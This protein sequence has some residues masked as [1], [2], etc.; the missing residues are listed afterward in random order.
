MRRKLIRWT[1]LFAVVSM[2]VW[3]TTS[4]IGG[5]AFKSGDGLVVG[6]LGQISPEFTVTVLEILVRNGDEVKK[7]DMVARVSSSRVA[8]TIA[9]LTSQS[10]Q[11]GTRMA[12][13]TS[14]AGVIDQMVESA[15]ARDRI[16]RS[17]NDALQISKDKGYLPALTQ[18]AVADQMFKGKQELELLRT[19]KETM[20]QQVGQIIAASRSTDQA[21]L[22]LQTLFDA[23]R[24][25]APMDGIISGVEAGIGSVIVPGSLVA[26]MVGK[27]RYIVA[28]FPVSRLYE[29]HENAPVTIEVGLGKWLRGSIA[30]VAPIAQRLPK[31][32]QKTLAPVER[33]QLV[34]I[35]FDKDV[36]PPPYFTKV[37]IR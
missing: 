8:E 28:Y 23:G 30:H 5:Y 21:I 11:L 35:N 12:E 1:Y 7:G 19:E 13:I 32:F 14:K 31:E 24:M 29:L 9:I 37:T 26:E 6:D 15:E 27:E 3:I 18:L 25:K 10:S 2:L 16:I 34:R 17:T 36:E 22:D 4:L 33:Q 20:S